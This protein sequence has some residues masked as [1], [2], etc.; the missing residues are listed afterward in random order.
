MAML[1]AALVCA[2]VDVTLTRGES[3]HRAAEWT[4]PA[5]AVA[6]Y[7]VWGL[8]TWIPARLVRRRPGAARFGAHL[9]VM[10]A[11]V[12][13]H[14]AVRDALRDTSLFGDTDTW[15]DVG[16]V[17]GGAF[18]VYVVTR[19]L[20]RREDRRRS[21][22]DDDDGTP[23]A[24]RGLGVLL[25]LG[26]LA[27]M[28]PGVVHDGPAP[29]AAATTTDGARPPNLLLL[30][31][32]TTRAQNLV[33][34]GYQRATTPH[35]DALAERGAVFDNAFSTTIFTL[36]S[37]TSMLTGVT[38]A[39][40]GTTMTNQWVEHPTIV[41]A[42]Q[43]AGYRTG[44]FVGTKVLRASTNFAEGFDV[45]DDLVDPPVCDTRLWSL[46]HDAQAA[47]AKAVPALSGDGNPHWF[48]TLQRPADDVL[49]NAAA[50]IRESEA[51][52]RPWFVFVNMFDVHWPYLPTRDARALFVDGYS[53]PMNGYVFRADDYPDGHQP[54]ASDKRHVVDLYDA[55][56]YELDA[57]VDRFLAQLDLRDTVVLTTSDHG[58]GFGEDRHGEQMWS[59]EHL[60]GPQT[61]IPLV[62]AA[63][64]VEAGRRVRDVV[65]GVDVAPTLLDFAGLTDATSWAMAGESLRDLAVD[66]ERLVFLQDHDNLEPGHDSAAVILGDLKLFDLEG[67]RSLHDIHADPLDLH[68]VSSEHPELRATLGEALDAFL[69]GSDTGGA[70]NVDMDVL[71]AL[72]Y[73]D[74]KAPPSKDG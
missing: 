63:P 23:P 30:V 43:R 9:L 44:G 6:A 2:A 41:P 64:G 15:I 34:Y 28:A 60:H 26:S 59:H 32:D 19:L 7:A 53:G 21:D 36:S 8:V 50:F 65:S 5:Q 68:D 13:L 58:E 51:A 20:A 18:T 11:P 42:L 27:V 10:A 55:E 66:P 57:E 46:V 74:G 49:A 37:H 52:G 35:L 1:L 24:A 38:P 56:L 12:A 40:H 25:A 3:T 4:L 33:P 39:E 16:L 17:L 67:D 73:V 31:W 61:R 62:L 70:G 48:E 69:D 47:A 45:Y 54:T 14:A 29:V 72:G 71:R 22:D